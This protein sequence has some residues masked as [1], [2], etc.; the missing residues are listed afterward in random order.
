MKSRA[1]N[2]S[3]ILLIPIAI[4]IA[5]IIGMY[6]AP[7]RLPFDEADTVQD[8]CDEARQTPW[9][10]ETQTTCDYLQDWW[11]IEYKCEEIIGCRTL[12]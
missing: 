8:I 10:G 12:V 5:F 3:I 11:H 2:I 1:L 7:E 4:L 9:I 6:Q